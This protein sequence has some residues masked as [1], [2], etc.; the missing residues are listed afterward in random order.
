MTHAKTPPSWRV[1]EWDGPNGGPITF[2][3]VSP[4]GRTFVTRTGDCV[5]FDMP[6]VEIGTFTASDYGNIIAAI[7]RYVFKYAFTNRHNATPDPRVSALEATSMYADSDGDLTFTVTHYGD[8]FAQV[9]MSPEGD[10]SQF[11][12]DHTELTDEERDAL[13]SVCAKYMI[14]RASDG[15][16]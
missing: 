6:V 11:A 8:P 16:W 13:R 5:A 12:L 4:E 14:S 10:W 1:N 9:Y 15:K 2:Q 3:V 7:Q